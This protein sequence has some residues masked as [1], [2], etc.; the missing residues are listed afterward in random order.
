MSGAEYAIQEVAKRLDDEYE[1]EVITSRMH[2]S[3]PNVERVGNITIH[4]VGF[5]WGSIDKLLS[6]F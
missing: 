4:R 5:G 6:P 2:S 1:W 3:L